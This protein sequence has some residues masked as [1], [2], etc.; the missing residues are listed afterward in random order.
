MV[1]LQHF[2][3]FLINLWPLFYA[4]FKER[5]IYVYLAVN[6]KFEHVDSNW[7]LYFH[8]FVFQNGFPSF[9]E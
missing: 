2:N 4:K 3:F 5:S 8:I 7:G 1:K 9:A 6:R